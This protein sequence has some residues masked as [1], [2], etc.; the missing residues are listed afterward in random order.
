MKPTQKVLTVILAV[1][2][3]LASCKVIYITDISKSP[4]FNINTENT[5]T[6][7]VAGLEGVQLNEFVNR[8]KNKYP[9]NSDFVVD[10]TKIFSAK[11]SNE[12]IFA[13]VNAD[14]S[15]QWNAIKSFAVVQGDFKTVDSLFNH[16]NSDYLIILTDF[17]I[18]NRF[19]W[20]S[21]PANNGQFNH[22]SESCIIKTRLVIFDVKSRKQVLEFISKGECGV[23]FG[24]EFTLKCTINHSIDHAV[25]YLKTG[26]IE[27]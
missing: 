3:L 14:T 22:A 4:D 16:C 26:N 19:D 1:Q 10:Y 24:F 23:A 9:K 20:S 11:L 21:L 12:K 6:A 7:I 8:F 17:E 13:R 18:S 25:S 2:I 5:K 27:F 15:G